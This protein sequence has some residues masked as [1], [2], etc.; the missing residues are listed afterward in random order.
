MIDADEVVR[1]KATGL[2]QRQ[3]ADRMG[4]SQGAVSL[5]LIARGI[6]SKDPRHLE[7][8][9]EQMKEWY[10]EGKTVQEIADRLGRHRVATN[11]VLRRI[12]CSMRRR[13]PKSGP[14]HT[15]WKGGRKFD[16]SGY[17]LVYMP[18][19]PYATAD[20]YVREHRLVAGEILGRD[21][22]PQEVVHH[23]NDDRSDN[24]PE[25]LQ[26][27][28]SNADHLRA[29]LTGRPQKRKQDGRLRPGQ[30]ARKSRQPKPTH[31]SPELGAQASQ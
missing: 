26:V 22:L 1:L 23:I 20:G 21:L 28:P 8:P 17:I 7:W 10:R 25:N 27:F 4:C 31:L 19:H 3:V 15:G 11:K 6:V 2:I 16:K 24:R 12:G 18:E 5:I 29:T 13:G 9:I 14:E 30:S